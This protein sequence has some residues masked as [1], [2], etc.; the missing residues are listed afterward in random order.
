FAEQ[1]E[2]PE[3]AL[4]FCKESIQLA[5]ENGLFRYRLGQLYYRQNR[6]D[7]ALKEFKQ[8]RRLGKDASDLISEIEKKLQPKAPR[9]A[10][11]TG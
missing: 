11:R 7:D 1:E 5:P 3:I 8:A 10:G 6:L 9:S 2:N 4:M